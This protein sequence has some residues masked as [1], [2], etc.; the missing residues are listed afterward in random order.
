MPSRPMPARLVLTVAMLGAASLCAAQSGVIRFSGMIVEPPCSFRF[1]NDAG[2]RL[3]PECPRPVAAD[4]SLVDTSG[5]ALQ[6][7][8][9]LAQAP[10]AIELPAR[11]A[12]QGAR[13]IAIVTYQ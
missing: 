7:T 10:G 13:W 9:R 5:R 8:V 1:S 11:Q 6:P 4:L 12:G 2:A 3:R